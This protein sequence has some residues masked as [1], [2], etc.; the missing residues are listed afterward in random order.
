M[1]KILGTI[2]ALFLCA[3]PIVS[4]AAETAKEIN[5]EDYTTLG[6]D[7]VLESEEMEKEYENYSENDDQISIYLFRGQGC[8]YCKAFLTF[9]NS[10]TDEYGKYFKLVS[11]E[12]WYDTDNASLLETLSEFVNN[13]AQGVPY[14]IIGENV[15]PG[16]ASDY[17]DQIKEAITTLY[18]SSERYDVIEAYNASL[19]EAKKAESSAMNKVIIYNLVFT[20]LATTVI[21]F[22]IIRTN[23][24]NCMCH[25][26][27]EN[28][29]AFTTKKTFKAEKV[30]EDD[31]EDEDDDEDFDDQNYGKE[32]KKNTSKKPNNKQYYKNNKKNNNRK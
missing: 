30:E 4:F 23:S 20:A 10:I 15:F 21:V 5:L 24:N 25:H 13:P 9:L 7:A 11:F 12:S 32:V 28:R 22:V 2:F 19:K 27:V 3:F 31:E 8:T 17:D 26:E 6:L 16:Y 18:E 1:K 29:Q 14:I